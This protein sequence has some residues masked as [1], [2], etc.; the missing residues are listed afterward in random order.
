MDKPPRVRLWDHAA[1]DEVALPKRRAKG[2]ELVDTNGRKLTRSV[3]PMRV[4]GGVGW[5]ESYRRP[6]AMTMHQGNKLHITGG[7]VHA[8]PGASD[9]RGSDQQIKR[10]AHACAAT[11]AHAAAPW[12]ENG[13][14]QVFFVM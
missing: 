2:V 12:R 6:V 1:V 11:R 13:A 7:T 5:K 10:G 4:V 9:N 3:D 8:T 14:A